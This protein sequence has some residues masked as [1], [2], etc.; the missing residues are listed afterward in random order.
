[1]FRLKWYDT[2]N[3]IESLQEKDRMGTDF[4]ISVR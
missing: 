4:H 2:G 3:E 1:M